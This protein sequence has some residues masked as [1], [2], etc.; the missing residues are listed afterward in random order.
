MRCRN[1]GEPIADFSD[2]GAVEEEWL[3]LGMP[4]TSRCRDGS[5][6]YAEPR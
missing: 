6:R 4:Q 3:H 1:C 2:E 5:S